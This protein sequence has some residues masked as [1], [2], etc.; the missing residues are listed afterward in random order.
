MAALVLWWSPQPVIGF[1]GLAALGFTFAPIYPLL[2]SM[3]PGRVGPRYLPQAV[4]LQ[5]AV[6]YLGTAALPGTA[7]A[8]AAAIG[9]TVVPPFLF[10]GTVVLALLYLVPVRAVD[11]DL[12][13]SEAL[14][15]RVLRRA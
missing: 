15:A 11:D 5:V 13:R 8:L 10:V 12:A 14:P 1:A 4:G 9:L 2:V 3:T 7:G 6:A